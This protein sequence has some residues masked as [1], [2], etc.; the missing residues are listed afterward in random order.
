MSL[1]DTIDEWSL[2][3]YAVFQCAQRLPARLPH[4]MHTLHWVECASSVTC[5]THTHICAHTRH[6]HL[7]ILDFTFCVQV[8]KGRPG[9]QAAVHDTLHLTL[10][11]TSHI[12]CGAIIAH[13]DVICQ[14][15]LQVNCSDDYLPPLPQPT[16]TPYTPWW[17]WHTPWRKP[18]TH[19]WPTICSQSTWWPSENWS[20]PLHRRAMLW[21][22]QRSPSWWC[23]T[24]TEHRPPH[25][26]R[27]E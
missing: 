11:H 22:G 18:H 21:G 5:D 20:V 16:S 4:A 15:I 3:L 7:F 23:R 27:T 1:Y 25:D 6:A 14:A 10:Q 9:T 19:T 17:T 8:T 13:T 2:T 12:E 24:P 26:S